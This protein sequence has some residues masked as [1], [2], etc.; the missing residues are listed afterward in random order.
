M[1]RFTET[2]AFVGAKA[3]PSRSKAALPGVVG[4]ASGNAA[5]SANDPL[6]IKTAAAT[7][8]FLKRSLTIVSIQ[9]S[10]VCLF[11]KD[12]AMCKHNF[13]AKP[14]GAAVCNPPSIECGG[15]KPPLFEAE[16]RA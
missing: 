12:G 2:G 4:P 11:Q 3:R 5:P 8:C 15:Y 7:I 6:A 13:L 1:A 16:G 9:P 14:Q 10:A